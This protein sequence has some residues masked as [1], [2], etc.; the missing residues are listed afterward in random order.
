MLR[1]NTLKVFIDTDVAFDII[2][3]RQPHYHQSVK[4]LQLASNEDLQ[5][6]TSELSLAN[7][8]YLSFDVYKLKDAAV[9][10]EDFI[11][12]CELI[13]SGKDIILHALRSS[14]KDKEDAVQYFSAIKTN[15]NYFITRNVKD[16][17][18]RTE[19]L[20]VCTPATFIAEFEKKL[21]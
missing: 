14:L 5:L 13:H 18:L 20:F 11:E 10:L 1:R 19:S 2:S 8:I 6:L 12:T 16:Y 7:L 17:K 9:L 3:K 21:G 15:C 4:L